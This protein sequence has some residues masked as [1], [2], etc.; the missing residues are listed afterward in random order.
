MSSSERTPLLPTSVSN[1]IPSR[2][3]VQN[4]LPSKQT[5]QSLSHA[6]GAYKAGKLPSQQQI[7]KI[8][9]LAIKSDFLKSSGGAGSRTAR[10]GEDG[11]RVLA[12]VKEVL[13]LVKKWGEEKNGDDLLQNIV[14]D[15]READTDVDTGES[16][17]E[18]PPTD[19]GRP[20]NAYSRQAF[21]PPPSPPRRS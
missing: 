8:I 13:N 21:P 15:V 1:S 7:S 16:R 18:R 6:L 5:Q 20:A 11:A 2:S 19:R 12:D 3:Q 4:S 17:F 14:Y 10:L 9:D